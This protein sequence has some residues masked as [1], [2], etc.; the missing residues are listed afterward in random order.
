[1]DRSG[2]RKIAVLGGT[3]NPIHKG[4]LAIAG[5]CIEQLDLEK[6]VFIPSRI[7]PHKVQ[8]GLI[9]A[10]LR[11]RM[12]ELAINGN[13][14]FDISR[15]E[16]DKPTVSYSVE[17]INAV[18]RE[19][20]DH[21]VYFIIGSDTVPELSKWYKIDQVFKKCTFIIAKRPKHESID[22]SLLPADTVIL[23][24]VYPDISSTAIRK[25]V[26]SNQPVDMFVPE[27]VA[28]FIKKHKLY[29]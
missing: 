11:Y 9:D 18:R 2:N 20:P 25:C 27:E 22:L 3:F 16:L 15:Y 12:A 10:E 19:Y 5:G 13:P 26:K 28:V 23:K 6:I 7:P 29:L 8:Q 21:K 17:T 4:H 14:A 24:G 1:M